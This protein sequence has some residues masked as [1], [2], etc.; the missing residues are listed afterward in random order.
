MSDPAVALMILTYEPAGETPRGTAERVLRA[1][2]DL[3]RYSGPLN[4]HIADDGSDAFHRE[5][6]CEIAGGYGQVGTVGVTNAERRG[7]GAS[8]N[9]ASQAVHTGADVLIVL[10]DD[11]LLTRD[12]DLDP[13]VETL[14]ENR[15]QEPHDPHYIGMIRLGYIGFTQDLRGGL[16]HTP[17]GIMLRLDPKSAE[18]HVPAGHARIETVEYERA[19]GPWTEGLPPGQTEF[20]WCKREP[21]RRGVAWPLDYGPASMTAQS[22]FAHIGARELGEVEPDG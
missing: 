10:E 7:Y 12:L 1:S 11:W 16:V 13:L 2:L 5:R 22:L 9:L 6:L 19:V 4:V 3:M 14:V 8:Y 20:D 18:P 21:A 17:A 15:T